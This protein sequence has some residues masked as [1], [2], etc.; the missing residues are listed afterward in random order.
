MSKKILTECHN[1]S[2]E[3][4][5]LGFKDWD[6]NLKKGNFYF[7]CGYKCPKCN[8]FENTVFYCKIKEK[9]ITEKCSCGGNVKNVEDFSFSF[10]PNN[11]IINFIYSCECDKCGKVYD[12]TIIGK[13][14]KREWYTCNQ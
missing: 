5:L 10:N 13:V 7:D 9:N 3:L 6:F 14:N 2:G 4:R 11:K 8:K 1:C 12:N